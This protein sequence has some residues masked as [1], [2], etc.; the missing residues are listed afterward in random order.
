MLQRA[1]I[2]AFSRVRTPYEDWP[3]YYRLSILP[4]LSECCSPVELWISS[5]SLFLP[6]VLWATNKKSYCRGKPWLPCGLVV[7]RSFFGRS[8]HRQMCA[9][10]GGRLMIRTISFLAR[11]TTRLRINAL[12][13]L[14]D[15]SVTISSLRI[16]I[17]VGQH[18]VADSSISKLV[19]II[20]SVRL[21]FHFHG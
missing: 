6:P 12:N 3:K 1:P 2:Q 11:F 15:Y 4:L 18:S 10:C 19:L 13:Y 17:K 16:H 9:V 20:H 21:S 8:G 14:Y 5:A 7:E